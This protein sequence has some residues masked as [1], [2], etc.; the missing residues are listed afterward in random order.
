MTIP[1]SDGTLRWLAD[2]L[3]AEE[4]TQWGVAT[5]MAVAQLVDNLEG[6]DTP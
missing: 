6:P 5:V 2:T 3:T 4:I 1:I